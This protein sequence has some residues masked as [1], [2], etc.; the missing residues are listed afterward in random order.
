MNMVDLSQRAISIGLRR[1]GVAAAAC[2]TLGLIGLGSPA[3]A[4]TN[5]IYN[6]S[7]AN[8]LRGWRTI[9]LAKGTEPGY[10]HIL[11][12]ATPFEPL[13]KC[14]RSQRGHRF[15]QLNVPAG[16]SASVE[17]SIIVPVNPG[18]LTLRAWGQLEPV[19]VTISLLSGPFAH[20]L[21]T[22]TPP[23]LQASPST[24]SKRKPLRES[25]SIAR[26]AG[27]ALSL[28]IQ[29]SSHALSG[30]IADFDRL[31]LEAR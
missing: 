18:H 24:C 10:P 8:G 21:A 2:L 26:Y 12:L 23:P 9:V 22:F 11:V 29:A 17:Q 25:L 13:L 20:R 14:E 3:L 28:R 4:G 19:K 15:L 7:F 1:R 16:A 30:A 6:A 31:S 27:Q 5:V